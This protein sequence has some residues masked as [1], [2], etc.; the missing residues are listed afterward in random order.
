MNRKK[1]FSKGQI[2]A[3][4]ATGITKVVTWQ[5]F[6]DF[7][8]ADGR[9]LDSVDDAVLIFQGRFDGDE[10]GIHRII[11]DRPITIVG[12]YKILEAV[13]REIAIDIVS[14]DVT[15]DGLGLKASSYLGDLIRV[16]TSGVTLCNMRIEYRCGEES[17][18]AI[19]IHGEET[20]S[21]VIVRNNRIV[22]VSH[23]PD[24]THH[25]TAINMDNAKDLVVEH[26]T[27]RVSIPALFAKNIRRD[28]FMMGLNAI[29]A[30][31][32]CEAESVTVTG[33]SVRVMVN[34]SG[35]KYISCHVIFV[36][37]SNAIRIEDNA[38]TLK[39]THTPQ[40][41]IIA[42]CGVLCG[43]SRGVQFIRNRFDLATRGG[44]STG[45]AMQGINHTD[46][47][48]TEIRENTFY[49]NSRGPV[50]AI[51]LTSMKGGRSDVSI[52]KNTIQVSGYAK[53]ESPFALVSGVE[54]QN[55][56]ASVLNNSILVSNKNKEYRSGFPVVGVGYV[57]RLGGSVSF[58]VQG[59]TIRTNGEYTV[60]TENSNVQNVNVT[61]NHL[62]AAK[63][64]GDDSVSVRTAESVLIE[65]AGRR[66]SE[67][68]QRHM[69]WLKKIHR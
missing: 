61:G 20:I 24:D 4:R 51:F 35:K 40:G 32:I 5:T 69:P 41:S 18:D 9:L 13:F 60:F 29:N 68:N 50:S 48:E 65:N 6:H 55:T 47:N 62:T 25:A 39:D 19:S 1:R 57:Q 49:C 16:Q 33:N 34:G 36:A 58:D 11:L 52:V 27:I 30:L 8:G 23:V 45:G 43:Y 44:V 64:T 21:D 37:G 53:D 10:L 31:R 26:N 15:I 7:F 56:V 46:C 3:I 14:G 59:N 67:T 12:D 17:S 63:R 28:Y 42:I 66:R 38:I 2:S 54:I 22:F